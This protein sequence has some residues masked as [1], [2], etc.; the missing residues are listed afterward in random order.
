MDCNIYGYIA[1]VQELQNFENSTKLRFSIADDKSYKKNDEWVNKANF[2]NC[3]LWNPSERKIRD[4]QKGAWISVKAD[5]EVNEYEKDGAKVRHHYFR[6]ER[7]I[8]IVPKQENGTDDLAEKTKNKM[9]SKK[10]D[11]NGEEVPF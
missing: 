4:I 6:V 3:E 8:K 9:K 2:V 7:V 5:Y 10:V 1:N 11:E